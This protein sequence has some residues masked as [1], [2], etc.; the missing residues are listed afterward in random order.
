[1]SHNEICLSHKDHIELLHEK[2][3]QETK[4]QNLHI[5]YF[6]LPEIK[7]ATNAAYKEQKQLKEE[8]RITREIAGPGKMTDSGDVKLEKEISTTSLCMGEMKE[9]TQHSLSQTSLKN[10]VA[11]GPFLTKN[12]LGADSGKRS[13]LR[14]LSRDSAK[15]EAIRPHWDASTVSRESNS[16]SSAQQKSNDRNDI[17]NSSM[18]DSPKKNL[19]PNPSEKPPLFVNVRTLVKGQVFGLCEVL[20]EKQPSFSLVSNGVECIMIDKKFFLEHAS[21]GHMVRLREMTFPYPSDK[22]LQQNLESEI[23]W[24][25]HKKQIFSDVLTRVKVR[26]VDLNDARTLTQITAYT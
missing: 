22:E 8:S 16:F 11:K 2:F 20:F 7:I 9:G 5:G 17:D 13:S 18:A 10:L 4:Q 21:Y 25:F 3:I 24:N 1:M 15:T 14:L 12:R 26:K 6:A 19:Q 23:L